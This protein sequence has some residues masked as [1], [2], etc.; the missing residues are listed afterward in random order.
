[1]VPAAR[2]AYIGTVNATKRAILAIVAA[3]AVAAAGAVLSQRYLPAPAP[4]AG[5]SV[6]DLWP[7]P[8]SVPVL[9][10]DTFTKV[11]ERGGLQ[12]EERNAVVSAVRESFDVRRLRAGSEMTL[13]WSRSG[14]LHL[15]EYLIDSD[16]KLRVARKGERFTAEILEIPSTTQTVA[17]SGRIRGSLFWSMEQ[18]GERPE[19]ALLAAEIFAWDLDFYTDP[20]E[21]DEFSLLVEKKEYANGQ[22][23]MYQRI[24]AARYDNAGTVYEAYLFPDQQGKARYFSADGKSLQSAFLRSPL[25]FDARVT[26][27]FTMSRLHPVLR[28][29]RP[30]LGTDY[31]APAGTPV[32]A[33]GSGVVTAAGRSGDAGNM[34]T[35]KHAGSYETQY[36]HLS[37]VSVRRGQRVEQGQQIGLVGTTGLSTGPHLDFRVRR[38]G[39]YV[40]FERLRLPRTE[41]LSVEEMAAFAQ[42]RD[43]YAAQ[44]A[45]R[46]DSATEVAAVA[47]PVQGQ[48]SG[49]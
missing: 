32:Q 49:Q 3:G 34:V 12:P 24:L 2:V 28:I 48:K 21:G 14:A 33:I 8:L 22:P 13:A 44:L 27:R 10:R 15:L 46:G 42:S 39:A 9:A 25:R 17:V 31:A 45:P 1:M 30:H 26:S 18:A 29:R 37:R 5:V 36:L 19:L 7:V 16:R 43:R 6:A 23:P 20:R 38:N 4:V 11:L 35:V 41:S 40:D 47:G